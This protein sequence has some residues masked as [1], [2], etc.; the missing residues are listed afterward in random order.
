MRGVDPNRS[1]LSGDPK[2]MI[3]AS[4]VPETNKNM[5]K[6]KGSIDNISK[7]TLE[8]LAIEIRLERANNQS[9][10]I[11]TIPITPEQLEP[12]GHGVY[13]FEYDGNRETGFIK[14]TITR[15]LSNGNELRYTSP[16]QNR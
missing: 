2:A 16:N 14:Y 7:E 15:L 8:G 9:P 10:E 5:V 3:F 13:E 4:R 1:T 11:R 6:A 12:N